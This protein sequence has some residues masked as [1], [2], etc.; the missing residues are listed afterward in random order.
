VYL[1]CRDSA[2]GSPD[3]DESLDDAR[4]SILGEVESREV[5]EKGIAFFAHGQVAVC[6]KL[7]EVVPIDGIGEAN[8]YHR[9]TTYP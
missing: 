8:P 2:G 3:F 5:N 4:L 6:H 7:R 1:S 9:S